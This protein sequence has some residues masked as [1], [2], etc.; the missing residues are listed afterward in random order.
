MEIPKEQRIRLSPT[1][2]KK[3][4]QLVDIRASCNGF[5]AC[6]YCGRNGNAV[7]AFHHHHIRFRSDYGSDT[8]ENL[9]LLCDKCHAKAHGVE[10]KAFQKE[11]LE[12]VNDDYA[13][14][15][16]EMY[17]TEAQEIYKKYRK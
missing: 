2:Y 7:M 14:F 8:L 16:N 10:E 17:Q 3:I 4:C 13:G 1:G 9:I 11:L 15:F 5:M 12:R 6:E